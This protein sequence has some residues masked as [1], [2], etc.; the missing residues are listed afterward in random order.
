MAVSRWRGMTQ[1]A[2]KEYLRKMRE[3][4]EAEAARKLAEEAARAAYKPKDYTSDE[5][6]EWQKKKQ[7]LE[8][9]FSSIVMRQST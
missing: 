9:F 8:Q 5:K 4:K 6:V 2:Q 7:D 3:D 1:R